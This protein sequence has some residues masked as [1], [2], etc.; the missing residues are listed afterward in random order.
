MDLLCRKSYLP[1]FKEGRT[2]DWFEHRRIRSYGWLDG[3]YTY[4][5]SGDYLS[6][7]LH[8]NRTAMETDSY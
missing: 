7:T 4:S 6:E 3:G 2:V 8:L 1:S 5:S